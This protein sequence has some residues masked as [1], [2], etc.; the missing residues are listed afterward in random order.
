[1]TNTYFIK[2]GPESSHEARYHWKGNIKFNIVQDTGVHDI[3]FA[4]LMAMLTLNYPF[5]SNSIA[6]MLE[7]QSK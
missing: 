7:M 5:T 2:I 3:Q 4:F 1:M 6:I